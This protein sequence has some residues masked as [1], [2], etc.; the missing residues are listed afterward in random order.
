MK[1]QA[2]YHCSERYFQVGDMVFLLLQPYKQSFLKLK[3]RHKMDPTFYGTY[4]FHQKL[5]FIAYELELPPSS[6]GH[7]IFHVSCLKKVTST[8]IRAQIALL[9]LDNEGSI[10][11]EMEE[12]LNNRTRQLHSRSIIEVLIQWHDMQLE[13]A[14][15]EP[16]LHIQQ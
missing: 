16:V 9:E 7:P 2:G 14:T 15:W 10:M 3:G 4:K 12:I 5:G 1:H 6:H 11:L 13:D 8:N